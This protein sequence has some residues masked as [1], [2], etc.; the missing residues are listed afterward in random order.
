MGRGQTDAVF[1]FAGTTR[2]RLLF[3]AGEIFAQLQGRP[4]AAPL[5]GVGECAFS[6]IGEPGR[7]HRVRFGCA[8]VF[9]VICHQRV[10]TDGRKIEKSPQ[11]PS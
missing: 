1:R 11:A 5:F 8:L 7:L 9:R 6:T 2:P 3:A 4:L 10:I